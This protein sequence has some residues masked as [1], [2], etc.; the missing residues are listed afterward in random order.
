[1]LG[2]S[3]CFGAKKHKPKRRDRVLAC[4]GGAAVNAV[5]KQ[6]PLWGGDSERKWRMQEGDPRMSELGE[7]LQENTTPRGGSL[8]GAEAEGFRWAGRGNRKLQQRQGLSHADDND[9]HGTSESQQGPLYM[10]GAGGPVSL[11]S[12]RKRGMRRLGLCAF[13]RSRVCIPVL[14]RT[15]PSLALATGLRE[16]RCQRTATGHASC[17]FHVRTCFTD[18]RVPVSPQSR[19]QRVFSFWNVFCSFEG[20]REP[21]LMAFA[22]RAWNFEKHIIRKETIQT[23]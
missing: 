6:Q 22:Y 17:A 9:S 8:T 21:F 1:M 10:E 12:A 13:S 11:G 20:L 16:Q 15:R 14:I 3:R 5:A 4:G 18:E 7:M 2:G 23:I 19:Q